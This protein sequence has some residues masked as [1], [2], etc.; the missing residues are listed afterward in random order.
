MNAKPPVRIGVIGNAAIHPSGNLLG[1]AGLAVLMRSFGAKVALAALVPDD[2]RGVAIMAKLRASG[3]DMSR[4]ETSPQ[5][6]PRLKMGDLID[7][8][9]LFDM[10]AVLVDVS[11]P[12][13]HRFLVDLPVHTAP[14]AR[15]IGLLGRLADVGATDAWETVLRHDAVIASALELATVVGANLTAGFLDDIRRAMM[16]HNLRMVALL[17]RNCSASIIE[18][19]GRISGEACAFDRFAAAV[20]VVFAARRPWTDVFEMANRP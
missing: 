17:D 7:V 6:R 16:G 14:N 4:V 19:S 8:A 1:S 2:Q 18:Q 5:P 10:D 12:R 13:L 9:G 15:L 3:V 11:D 20:T